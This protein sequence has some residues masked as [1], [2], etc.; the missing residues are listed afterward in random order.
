MSIWKYIGEIGALNFSN[1]YLPSMRGFRDINFLGNVDLLCSN[2]NE[3]VLL[4]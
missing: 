4:L 1:A 3:L 2:L